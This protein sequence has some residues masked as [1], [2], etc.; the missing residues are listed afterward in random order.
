MR[1]KCLMEEQRRGGCRDQ[2]AC[3]KFVWAKDVW[4][5]LRDQIWSKTS[6][7][8]SMGLSGVIGGLRREKP[9]IYLQMP[10]G[11]GKNCKWPARN[12]LPRLGRGTCRWEMGESPKDPWKQCQ[13]SFSWAPKSMWIVTAATKLEDASSLEEELWQI[14]AVY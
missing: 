10:W 5:C 3:P 13:I 6:L 12:K 11:C 9:E 4:V 7:D 1:K 14:P 2:P 8:L